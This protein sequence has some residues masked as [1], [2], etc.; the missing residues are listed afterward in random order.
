[1]LTVLDTDVLVAA[2]RSETGASKK[3]L[4]C[5]LQGLVQI[6]ASVPLVLEYEAVLTRKQ[7]LEAS[8]LSVSD[9]KVLLDALSRMMHPVKIHYLWR[10][11][12]NDPCD[13]MVL[14][15]AINGEADAITTFNSR[16]FERV[17][18]RFE[19]EILSPKDT[20]RRIMT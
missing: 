12:L 11:S 3:L 5:A 9:V 2:I 18:E 8:G 16:H 19:I 13:E 10:P 1:M 4:D 7:H 17:S 6:A 15:A 14:E 20:L